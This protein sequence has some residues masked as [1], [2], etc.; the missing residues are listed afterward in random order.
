MSPI[1]HL[2][3]AP[4]KIQPDTA[5]VP[6]IQID[7]QRTIVQNICD[8]NKEEQVT[9]NPTDDKIVLAI[10]GQPAMKSIGQNPMQQGVS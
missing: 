6:Q 4:D 2:V 5:G 3:L 9:N 8:L 1:I 10:K 7:L